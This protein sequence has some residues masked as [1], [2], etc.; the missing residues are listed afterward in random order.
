[1]EGMCSGVEFT[2]DVEMNEPLKQQKN[3]SLEVLC[4]DG[5]GN[6][7]GIAQNSRSAPTSYEELGCRLK[8]TAWR[9]IISHRKQCRAALLSENHK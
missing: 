4:V 9:R 5:R 2:G 3:N 6:E 1:M 8:F 7:E